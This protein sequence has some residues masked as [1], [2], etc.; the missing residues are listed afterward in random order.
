[1]KYTKRK[2]SEGSLR[3]TQSSSHSF[4]SVNIATNNTANT[5]QTTTELDI[6]LLESYCFFV[7]NTGTSN[8]ATLKVQLSPNAIDWVDD[9]PDT[10]LP[11]STSTII[12]ANKF[13]KYIRI[14][15]KSTVSGKPTSI[16][17][18]FQGQ[19]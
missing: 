18:I 4:T 9:S 19:G 16:S 8:S 17:V 12:T 1:M 6:S 13:L 10:L 7:K 3:A 11:A 14:L 5:Y 2:L 15:Y